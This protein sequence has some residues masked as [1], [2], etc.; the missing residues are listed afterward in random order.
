MFFNALFNLNNCE[1]TLPNLRLNI[2]ETYY[3][4]DYLY[5]DEKIILY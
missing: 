4:G 5:N 1:K 2:P 3:N